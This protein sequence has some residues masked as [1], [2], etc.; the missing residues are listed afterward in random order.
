M[1]N[2]LVTNQ[3]GLRPSLFWDVDSSKLSFTDNKDFII[4]RVFDRGTWDE[5][6][7]L[8]IWYGEESVKK[9]VMSA[10]SLRIATI[11]LASAFFNTKP[12]QFACYNTKQSP[13]S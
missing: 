4:R 11:Y 6:L 7:N 2:D 12:E 5:I 3:L 10:P 13:L 8:V 1:A 9:S